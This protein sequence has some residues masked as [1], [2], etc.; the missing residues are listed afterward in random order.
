LRFSDQLCTQSSTACDKVSS[1][2]FEL[3]FP[4]W[5]AGANGIFQAVSTLHFQRCRRV[6]SLSRALFSTFRL[7]GYIVLMTAAGDANF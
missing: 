1:K 3:D 2:L 7:F 5:F 6:V 4:E